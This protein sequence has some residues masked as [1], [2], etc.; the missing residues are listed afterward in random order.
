MPWWQRLRRWRKTQVGQA[1]PTCEDQPFDKLRAVSEVE[2]RSVPESNTQSE[3]D[4][5]ATAE[6]SGPVFVE[7]TDVLDLHAFAPRDVPQV[8]EIYLQEARAKGYSTVRIIHGKGIGMQRERV[9]AVLQRTP[10]VTSYA[11]APLEAGSWGAT[12]V[13]FAQ[14]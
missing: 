11:D 5:E 2:R 1:R 3:T 6:E 8:I 10:F 9:R 14:E 4:D 12:V 13:W 7:I